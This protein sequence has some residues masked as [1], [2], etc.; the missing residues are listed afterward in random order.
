MKATSIQARLLLILLPFFMLSFGALVGVSYYLSQ[1]AL[2]KSV[3]ETAMSLGTDY[4]NRMQ[5]EMQLIVTQ[6]ED[7]A[8]IQRVRTGSD[9]QQIFEALVEAKK[10]I[11]KLDN[12]IYISPD[13]SAINS[14]GTKSQLGDREYFKKV[15][16][17]KKPVISD[18]LVSRSTGKSSLYVAVPVMYNGQLTGVLTGP[19]ALE[20][21]SVMI[22]DLKFKETGYGAIADDSGLLIAHPYLPD[23]VGKF[24]YL[25]KK[26]NPELKLQ[27]TELD[28]RLINLFS[29]TASGK[30]NQGKY[31][32]VDGITR[33]AVYT[34]IDLPG[35]QR[36]V[37][38]VAAPEAETTAETTTLA[39]TL[40]IIS[41][42]FI[43]F[44]VLFIIL[45]S[46]RFAKPIALIRDEC[47]LL[48][49]GDL[50]EREEKVHS[51][52]EIGQ[53]AHGFREMR[54]N[55][56]ALVTKVQSQAEQVAASS[57]ELTAS[58]YQSADAANQVAGSITEIANG[59]EKQATSATHISAVAE[60]MFAST[61]QVSTAARVVSEIAGN[62]SQEAELGRQAVE[63]AICQMKKI[64]QG[65]EA[66]QTA[67]EELAKGSYEISEI[68][69][70]IASIAG[71][72]NL[73]A[74]NAAIEAARAGEHGRGFAV[75]AE[76]VRK[77]AEQSNQATQQIGALIER[78]QANMDQAVLATKVGAEGIKTGVMVV[79]SAGETFKKI[80]GSITKLSDQTKEI[81][82]SVNQMASGSQTLVTSINEIDKVSKVNAGEAQSVSAATEEQSA[83][84]QEIASSS[85][86][87]A[88]LAG[89][90]QQAVAKFRV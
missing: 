74:L 55:L 40:L 46:K 71:Q 80:V 37:M 18:P 38:I 12:F 88:K 1:Q 66:V 39:R 58:A 20:K 9:K 13:G 81:A 62:T 83:S 56:R 16:E 51:Q 89:D 34:P 75:V 64:G 69:D 78:N 45:M 63:Q 31:V 5:A 35:N 53:L 8:S 52:D 72:T 68:V 27:Q 3:D 15:V 85:Q 49:Q 36:W 24:N 14:D 44:A 32:F 59:T 79:N 50:R 70:L 86:S 7:L 19:F 29:A 57:E 26:I 84:M 23:L 25:Q 77:L 28:D 54:T 30:Q 2:V 82:D 4:S 6:L 47:M 61:K 10:R 17:T 43:G 90:L 73:L 60:E 41:L 76:E 65:S 22:K 87:L 33:V 11:G 48:T 21:L 42:I 67:I